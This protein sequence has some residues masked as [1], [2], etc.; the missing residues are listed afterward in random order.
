MRVHTRLG[1]GLLE[2]A[3]ETCLIYELT[4]SGLKVENQKAMP[5]I[6]D[7]VKMDVGYRLDILVEGTVVVEVKAVEY[8]NDVHLAQ[9]I[10][11]LNLSKSKIGLIINFNVASL[12]DGI[13]RVI[14]KDSSY[15]KNEL[16]ISNKP[17]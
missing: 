16:E 17:L 15:R 13:K 12:K 10:T 3:Y 9:T 5:L 7:E 1:P 2:S 11:Y 8:I 4:K 14:P 6:Y